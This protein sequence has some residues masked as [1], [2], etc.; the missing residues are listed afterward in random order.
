MVYL[1]GV[2]LMIWQILHL[3]N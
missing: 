3:R 2:G 1:L